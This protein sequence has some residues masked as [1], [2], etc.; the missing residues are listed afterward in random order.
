MAG[1]SSTNVPAV[2]RTAVKHVQMGF[3]V[4]YVAEGVAY[5]TGGRAAGLEEGMIL[6]VPESKKGGRLT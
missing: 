6:L 3:K 1:I 5:L 4:K 2:T